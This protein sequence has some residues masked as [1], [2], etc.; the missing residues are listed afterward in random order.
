MY[1]SYSQVTFSRVQQNGT[2]DID[3][4]ADIIHGQSGGDSNSI[5]TQPPFFIGGISREA[6]L[7]AATNVEVRT[8]GL[9]GVGVAGSVLVDV[10]TTIYI[11]VTRVLFLNRVF[12][13]RAPHG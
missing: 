5:N 13:T 8:A 3:E 10:Y 12:K 1:G 6:S 2:L 7:P 11:L 4:G 9:G